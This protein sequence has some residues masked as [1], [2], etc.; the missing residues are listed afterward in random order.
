MLVHREDGHLHI[1][2]MDL[3]SGTLQT[4]T[5]GDLDKS[6]SFAPNGS[7]I[8]FEADY[9]D[10]GVLEMV[11]VDGQVR[12]RL[13]ERQGGVDVHAPVWGPFLAPAP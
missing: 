1:A 10:R 7:M 6:P 9:N 8:I 5:D 4:L 11:S 2:L 13:S 12:E 3:A